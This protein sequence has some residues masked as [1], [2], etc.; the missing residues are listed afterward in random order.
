MPEDYCLDELGKTA[1]F[2]IKEAEDKG[3]VIEM[4]MDEFQE[5]LGEY[6]EEVQQVRAE[7]KRRR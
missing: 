3:E 1:K 4:S 2:L 7:F 6:S 5:K